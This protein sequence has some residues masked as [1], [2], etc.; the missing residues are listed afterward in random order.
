VGRVSEPARVYDAAVVGGGP[1]GCSAAICLVRQGAR[2]VLLE[3]RAYPHDKLCGEFLSPECADL[4][5]ELG[6]TPALRALAP[7]SIDTVCL[8][9]PNGTAW[10][11]RLPGTALG[12][13]RRALDQSLAQQA[14]AAGVE[15]R[16]GAAVTAIE[17]H[18]AQ[19]FTLPTTCA[20]DQAVRART[21]IAAHGKRGALDRSLGRRF[22]RQSQPFLALKA[23]FSGP[24]L[25]GRIELHGFP[26]GY[27]GMSEIEV[28]A[29]AAGH[30]ANVCLLV[31]DTIFRRAGGAGPQRVPAFVHWMRAQNPRLEAW[32]ARATQLDERWLSIAQVP[33]VPKRPVVAE[34][35]MAGD[36]A[37]L[38]VPLAGDGIAMALRSGQLAAEYCLGFLAGRRS[39]ASLME[40]YARAW[41][42]EF[43]T[44]LRLGRLL[45]SVMLRPRLM[46][47]G[48]RLLNAAPALARYVVTRTR[49]TPAADR[50]ALLRR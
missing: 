23:H 38:I 14:R 20:G 17:G 28:G 1:A 45:Q 5:D 29:G 37:G 49:A 8:T 36:A 34:V 16:A 46:V 7:V 26:G 40:G 43:S 44:R 50:L 35:L 3:A 19:G 24:P 13:T 4:L 15:V 21:V 27:C 42:D 41:S 32:L 10:E 30:A 33:F 11:C 48:L 12:L 31:H 6:V 25:P 22:L 2:V 18:L 39:A 47:L 9:A